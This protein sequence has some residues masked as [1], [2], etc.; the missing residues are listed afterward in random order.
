MATPVPV[1]AY[2]RISRVGKR[3]GESFISQELQFKAIKSFA[4]L[5]GLEIIDHLHEENVSGGDKTRA[6]WNQALSRVES[7]EAKGI[8]V[9]NI[10]RFSRSIV[11]ALDA[12]ERIQEAGGDLY[13]TAG[14]VGDNTPGGKLIRGVF[15]QHACQLG[16]RQ[17]VYPDGWN[18]YGKWLVLDRATRRRWIVPLRAPR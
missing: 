14:D 17:L 4:E 3:E 13:S 7:G 11:D 12:I 1:I 6:G 16:L 18:R 8:L 9:Y 10:S 5:R 15:L 2:T